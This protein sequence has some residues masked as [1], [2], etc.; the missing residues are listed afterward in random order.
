MALSRQL[1]ISDMASVAS[2]AG[3][4]QRIR[5]KTINIGVFVDESQDGAH[6]VQEG[7]VTLPEEIWMTIL[8]LLCQMSGDSIH[9]KAAALCRVSGTCQR[10]L[11]FASRDSLWAPLGF[12]RVQGFT[13]RQMYCHQMKVSRGQQAEHQMSHLVTVQQHMMQ[14]GSQSTPQQQA[15][16][17]RQHLPL[18][19]LNLAQ[20]AQSPSKK[21]KLKAEKLMSRLVEEASTPVASTTNTPH[22]TPLTNALTPHLVPSS[23]KSA[24]KVKRTPKDTKKR[25]LRL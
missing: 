21:D 22:A 13:A 3:D 2:G 16:Y 8:G 10:L 1:T 18:H 9:S 20:L 17:L 24:K 25:L 4:T 19:T 7:I 6:V 12:K 5:A 23:K 14:E 11:E 15:R